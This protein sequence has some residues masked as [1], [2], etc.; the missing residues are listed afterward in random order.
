[1]NKLNHY[2]VLV[3]GSGAGGKLV[4]WTMA[5]KGHRTGVVERT[6]IGGS[7]ANVACLRSRN[8]I[9]TAKVASLFGRHHEF[10][11]QTGTIAINMAE[12]YARKRKIVDEIVKVNL[13]RYHGRRRAHSRPPPECVQ[14]V[15]I[16]S[17]STHRNETSA[18]RKRCASTRGSPLTTRLSKATLGLRRSPRPSAQTS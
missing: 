3:L 14:Q 9:H 16:M 8:V 10:G 7:C 17:A 12:V 6:F 13:D 18:K 1:M 4:A 2:D 15:R 11:I 5:R